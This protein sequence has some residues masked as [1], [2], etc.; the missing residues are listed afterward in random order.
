MTK[1]LSF[2]FMRRILIKSDF[3]CPAKTK[4]TNNQS[5]LNVLINNTLWFLKLAIKISKKI[6]VK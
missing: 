1:N 4:T 6:L 3:T 2:S 5:Y